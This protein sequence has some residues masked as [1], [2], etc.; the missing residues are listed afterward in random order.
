[1][2]QA[3]FYIV[4]EGV[5]FSVTELFNFFMYSKILKTSV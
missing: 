2:E 5:H 3:W 1:M 4:L